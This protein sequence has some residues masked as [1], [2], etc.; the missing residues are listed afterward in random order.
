ME[1]DG[2]RDEVSAVVL[3]EITALSG[4]DYLFL[5]VLVSPHLSSFEHLRIELLTIKRL[6]A[7]IEDRHSILSAIG[8]DLF[9][10]EVADQF[11]G[12]HN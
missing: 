7:E 10:L 12:R 1:G 2:D 3:C 6:L 4:A 11:F 8:G 5:G 9:E